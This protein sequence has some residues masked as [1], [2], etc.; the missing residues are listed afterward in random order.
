MGAICLHG[1]L[2]CVI[3]RRGW[4][5]ERVWLWQRWCISSAVLK[6][7]SRGMSEHYRIGVGAVSGSLIAWEKSMIRVKIFRQIVIG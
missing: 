6:P 2:K 5:G 4:L 1:V 7:D 3:V